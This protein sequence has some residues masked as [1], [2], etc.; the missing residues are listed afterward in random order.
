M[1]GRVLA[2]WLVS[3]VLGL[4]ALPASRR[5]FSRLPDRGYGLSRALGILGAGYFFWLGGSLGVLRN[6]LGGA[7]LAVLGVL[8]VSA[9]I[10]AGRWGETRDWIAEHRRTVVV[11]EAVFA[12]SYAAWTFVRANN[13]EIAYTEK[14]ME[15]AF[16]ES[17]MRS[18]GFPAPDPWLS[19]H[20]IS[21]YHFGYI[22]LAFLSRLTGTPPEIAFNLGNALWFALVALGTYSI[23]YNLLG[24]RSQGSQRRLGAALLG[25]LFVLFTGNLEG[26]FEVLHSR[27]VFWRAGADGSLASK[28]WDWL[29]LGDLVRPPAL[30]S[31]WLPQRFWM[32][33]QASRVVNDV[34]LA[35]VPVDVG[36]IDEFPYFSFLLADNHPHL[37]ALPFVLLAISFALQVFLS[38]KRGEHRLGRRRVT[39]S[40]LRWVWVAAGLVLLI[41]GAERAG[42][43]L[44][45]GL[46]TVG[47]VQEGVKVILFGGVGLGMVALLLLLG[48]GALPSA[49]SNAEFWVAGW[50]FG[51][52]AFLNTWDW[53]IYLALLIGVLIW[54]GRSDP[55]P[56][57]AIRLLCTGGALL[58]AG[59]IFFLPWYPTFS[60]QAGGVLPNL[61]FPTR[62]PHFLIMFATSLVPLLAWLLWRA[63]PRR[64]DWGRLAAIAVGVPFALLLVS[65]LLGAL[66]VAFRPDLVAAALDSYA[67]SDIRTAVNE[68]LLGRLSTSWTALTLGLMLALSVVLLKKRA[69]DG[70]AAPPGDDPPWAFIGILTI[71]GALLVMG[72]EFLYLKDLFGVRMNTVFKFYFAAW[73]L[74]GLAAAYVVTELWPRIRTLGGAARGAASLT[75]LFGLVYTLTATWSKTE[76]FNPARGRTLDGTAYLAIDAPADYAAITWINANLEPGVLAEGVGGSYTQGGRISVHTGFPTV[77]GWPWHEVQW[78]GDARFL[79]TREDDIR[80]LYQSRDWIEAQEIISQYGIRYVYIGNFERDAYGSI[81]D[82]MFAAFMDVVYQSGEVTIYVTRDSAGGL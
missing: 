8:G 82:S 70:S 13:P 79:G 78:R 20:A 15:L 45:D 80:R 41:A 68:I 16:L 9:A 56:A 72:P 59:V 39:A 23:L 61:A 35:G 64:N 6:D 58:V 69:G 17:I 77:L 5:I 55:A 47:A 67:A 26:V 52:L 30:P 43:G 22:L 62:L 46:G 44:R 19:G 71:L 10:G 36:P 2:W 51:S 32:W 31:S 7:I 54:V 74:L 11:M 42:A 76:G 24:A 37:L 60:S 40:S 57:I 65:W 53:P 25:P 48:M 66:A 63:R 14:P 3:G 21:Y 81:Q 50:M 49:L 75:I 28:F 4:A 34:N 27:Y 12:L 29:N 33:W 38:G 18:P 73:I 1:I